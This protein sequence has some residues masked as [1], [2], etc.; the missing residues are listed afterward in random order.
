MRQRSG[1]ARMRLWVALGALAS[2][3][4]QAQ[5]CLTPP[6]GQ[7]V[8]YRGE[9]TTL[10][11]QGGLDGSFLGGSAYAAGKVG[12]AL[13]FANGP[14]LVPVRHVR[15]ADSPVLR[16]QNLT[17][18]GWFRLDGNVAATQVLAAKTLGGGT[19][20]SFVLYAHL[21]NYHYYFANGGVMNSGVE[22]R[23]GVWTHLALVHD[24]AG[25]QARL[26]ING[27]LVASSATSGDIGYDANP[28]TL[29]AELENGQM[30]FGL[31]GLIDELAL[32][33]RV[34]SAGEIA[35]IHAA[36]GAGKCTRPAALPRGSRDL[37]GVQA[38]YHGDGDA[39]D[40]SGFQRHGSLV[41]GASAVSDGLV[42]QAFAF[43]GLD[44]RVSVPA[45]GGG[46]GAAVAAWVKASPASLSPS[47]SNEGGINRRTA[48]GASC[49]FGG[50]WAMGIYNGQWGAVF[51]DGEGVLLSGIAA[52]TDRWH[53]LVLN[54]AGPDGTV[55][56]L[57]GV[58][59]ASVRASLYLLTNHFAI[60]GS[61]LD[62]RPHDAFAGLV[63]EVLV[64]SYYL[65]D[66]EVSAL[67]E[68][69]ARGA[70]D[71]HQV[72]VGSGA[73]RV[74]AS[75]LSPS[76]DPNPRGDGLGPAG[77]YRFTG[78]FCSSLEPSLDNL[79]TRTQ[80]L[81]N[82]NV[83]VNRSTDGSPAAGGAGSTVV[84]PSNG[85]AGGYAFDAHLAQGECTD[86]P[87]EIGL[88]N[89]NRFT[90]TVQLLGGR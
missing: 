19:D 8:W 86:V 34:L 69:G 50:D 26:Y 5:S 89:R 62:C 40:R 80:V 33:G 78:R 87:Y 21:G 1:W 70:H 15:V 20:D 2:G 79:F 58:P 52:D 66:A 44:D 17:L 54:V 83:L 6:T 65:S 88:Q 13:Q 42:G 28:F 71:I 30:D 75:V 81:G 76:T 90:F 43:D 36:G 7:K 67:Y 23:A 25:A 68:A 22:V 41:N 12:Q 55:L 38:Y 84:F 35:G 49:G 63:D 10:D 14:G 18:E 73:G 77:T 56:F 4:A 37:P 61:P 3:L 31:N 46:I 64:H 59:V 47:A 85:T 60:G 32:Y 74:Q 11:L 72:P 53:H 29:G 16:P 39:T 24:R 48:V 9:G 82:G 45:A 57:D 27:A 51:K